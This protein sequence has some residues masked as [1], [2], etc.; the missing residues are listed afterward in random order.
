MIATTSTTCT[1]VTTSTT[2]PALSTW[3]RH[4]YQTST[5]PSPNTLGFRLVSR[6]GL[7][8]NELGRNEFSRNERSRNERGV[9]MRVGVRIRVRV[10]IRMRIRVISGLFA[11]MI[12]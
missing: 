2:G 12:S 4:I 1:I 10:R 8:R 7:S 6:N 3:G 5:E 11:C 9:R